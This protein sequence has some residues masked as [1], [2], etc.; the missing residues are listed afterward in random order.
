MGELDEDRGLI[1]VSAKG[2]KRAGYW[3]PA[4][5]LSVFYLGTECFRTREEAVKKAEAL[6]DRKIAS[7]VR[8]ID[9]LKKKTF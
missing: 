8:Q 3:K 9:K 7:L 2:E 6:R 1:T 4:V 5:G